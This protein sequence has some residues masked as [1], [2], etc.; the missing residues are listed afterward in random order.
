MGYASENDFKER[1]G[2]LFAEIYPDMARE[3]KIAGKYSL[4][5]S[6][7]VGDNAK[8]LAESESFAKQALDMA[9]GRGGDQA[10]VRDGE[11]GYYYG[12][13]TRQAEKK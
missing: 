4:T 1:L 3:I 7:G 8:T 11:R 2:S 13:K 6:I 5:L 10:V 9:L 12:G